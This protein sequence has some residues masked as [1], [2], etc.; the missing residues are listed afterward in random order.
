MERQFELKDFDEVLC[1][2]CG[3]EAGGGSDGKYWEVKQWAIA[4]LTRANS[5]Q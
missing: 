5:E 2:R 3:I 4:D 1:Y